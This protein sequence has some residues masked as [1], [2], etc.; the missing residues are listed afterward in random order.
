M[1]TPKAILCD[2]GREFTGHHFTDYCKLNEIQ[3]RNTRL[4]S[5]QG[6][7]VERRNNDIRKTLQHLMI[8]NKSLKWYDLLPQVEAKLNSSWHSVL[9][10]APSQIYGETVGH[11]L[12]ER[13]H[14]AAVAKMEK[15]RSTEFQEG[16][17]CFVSSSAIYSG[18][19]DKFKAKKGKDVI[20]KYA[21]IIC[22]IAKRIRPSATV[23]ERPR[24]ELKMAYHPYKVLSNVKNT[25]GGGKKYTASR[26]YASDLIECTLPTNQLSIS[27]TQALKMNG[28]ERRGTDLVFH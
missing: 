26:L 9:R 19:R 18:V 5:P 7:P 4:Y 8:R 6:N 23:V 28:V 11:D 27:V 25:E 10:A 12:V 20:V 14:A 2:N 1:D 24:Y 17:R 21:H 3:I 22:E 13:N 15:Y 16:D